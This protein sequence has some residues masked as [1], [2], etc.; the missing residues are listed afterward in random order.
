MVA[1]STSPTLTLDAGRAE[2]GLSRSVLDAVAGSAGMLLASLAVGPLRGFLSLTVPGPLGL[3]L[4]GASALAAYLLALRLG[5]LPEARSVAF[6][7]VVA[8]QLAQ[9]L[10]AGR[11]EG[12]LSR[13]VLGAVAG[14]AGMLLAALTVGPLRDFFGL[15]MPGPTGLALVGAGA[16]VAMLI[17]RVRPSERP[18]VAAPIYLSA[19]P[20]GGEV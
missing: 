7:S 19:T 13:S 1:P 15:V 20:A 8:T 10:D 6:A 9:T 11:A 18:G 5:G 4:V 2:G 3:A 17:G 16:L 14:S 12:G